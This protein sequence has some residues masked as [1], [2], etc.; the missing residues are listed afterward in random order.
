[1]RLIIVT[2]SLIISTISFSQ[3]TQVKL[4]SPT[5]AKADTYQKVEIG[6][7]LPISISDQ[8]SKFIYE[9]GQGMNP[10]DPDDIDIRVTFRNG[11][12]SLVVPAFYMQKV[13]GNLETNKW[14]VQEQLYN[15]RARFSTA[16]PGE[17]SAH[18]DIYVKGKKWTKG[19]QSEDVVFEI[20]SSMRKGPIRRSGHSKIA[21]RYLEHA[22]GSPFFAI[23]ENLC[24]GGYG[25]LTPESNTRHVRW[26]KEMAINGGNFTRISLVPWE[27]EF[28]WKQLNVYDQNACHAIDNIVETMDQHNVQAIMFLEIHDQFRHGEDWKTDR[29]ELNPYQKLP[30]VKTYQDF[31]TDSTAKA[32]YKKKLRYFLARWGYAN[33]TSIIELLSEVNNTFLNYNN[34]DKTGQG[35]RDML[36]EWFIEMKEYIGSEKLVSV[37]FATRE[38]DKPHKKIYPHADLMF[39]HNYG[40]NEGQNYGFR[41]KAVTGMMNNRATRNKPMMIEE[42]GGSNGPIPARPDSCT[43]LSFHN[44]LWS[45]C[46]MGSF[47]NGMNWWWDYASH[48]LGHYVLFKPA[49]KFFANEEVNT[50]GYLPGKSRDKEVEHFYLVS[51][52]RESIIGWVHN[53]SAYW[54]NLRNE[55]KCISSWLAMDTKTLPKDRDKVPDKFVP[56]PDKKYKLRGLKPSSPFKKRA[57]ELQWFDTRNGKY[58]GK[59]VVKAGANGRVKIKLPAMMEIGAA[60][61]AYKLTYIP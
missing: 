19:S 43:D 5:N 56:L 45:T 39:M 46:F 1:M 10:Y 28:E 24:W 59:Q 30:T 34:W 16:L 7:R 22:D 38:W 2:L 61:F 11:K 36:K 18:P 50:E 35:E 29:W 6:I 55:N 27:L 42:L 58:F 49:S 15:W 41:Y 52:D 20:K 37:S 12:D 25:S 13:S 21:S 33:S 23:G 31:F 40:Q 53:R 3:V 51:A 54:Y 14:M 8:I 4:V 48:N 44:N 47:G 26:I 32:V 9:G 57:Y 17:W 60:D